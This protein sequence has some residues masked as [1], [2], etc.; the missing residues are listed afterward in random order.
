MFV[1]SVYALLLVASRL[2][3]SRNSIFRETG[4]QTPTSVRTQPIDYMAFSNIRGLR[5]RMP[6]ARQASGALSGSSVAVYNPGWTTLEY[7]QPFRPI[8]EAGGGRADGDAEVAR[9]RDDGDGRTRDYPL[10][11]SPG[12]AYGLSPVQVFDE[13]R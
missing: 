11:H 2:I 6:G 5:C 3:F 12:I 13:R 9:H 10:I 1:L 8:R 4:R 7:P